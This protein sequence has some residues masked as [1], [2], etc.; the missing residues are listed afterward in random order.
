MTTS[1]ESSNE[2]RAEQIGCGCQFKGTEP[3]GIPLESSSVS[4]V[5]SFGPKL[6]PP[7]LAP[8]SP[9]QSGSSLHLWELPSKYLCAIVGTCATIPEIRKL[10]VKSRID[11]PAQYTD[12]QL[13]NI[14]V[15]AAHDGTRRG[16]LL[17]NCFSR[18][19]DPRLPSIGTKIPLSSKRFGETLSM[20]VTSLGPTMYSLPVPGHLHQ[21]EI[22]PWVR[23]ICSLTSRVCPAG[24][25]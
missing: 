13:H 9:H 21:S 11:N 12:Y 17:E 1:T 3:Q 4:S 22:K 6:T 23:S 18:N 15:N 25:I 14:F 7:P 20:A 19:F 10:A 2:H 8:E 5:S 24:L 16:R